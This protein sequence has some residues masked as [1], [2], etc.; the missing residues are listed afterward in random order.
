[1]MLTGGANASASGYMQTIF[2]VQ[3]AGSIDGKQKTCAYVFDFAPDRA[4]N[5]ISEVH[6]LTRHG[7]MTD[8]ERRNVLGEFLNF[9]PVI[10]VEG[11][12]MVPYSTSSLMRQIKKITVDKAVN[13]GFDDDSIYNEGVGIVMDGMMCCCLIS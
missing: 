7:K 3:S 10:S 11:T 4:L 2:R 6:E 13:S 1:M 8:E 9:C 12:R 5:V